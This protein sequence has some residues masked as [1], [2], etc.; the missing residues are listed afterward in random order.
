[1]SIFTAEH[2][3]PTTD[4]VRHDYAVAFALDAEDMDDRLEKFDRWL[5]EHDRQ[6][7]ARRR[8]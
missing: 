2:A 5:R 6:L 1:M 4:E 8:L 7:L 3:I